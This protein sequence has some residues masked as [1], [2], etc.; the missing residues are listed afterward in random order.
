VADTSIATGDAIKIH[1]ERE[2]VFKAEAPSELIL[3]DVPLRFTPV[4]VWAR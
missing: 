1:H 4:G 3:V 2:L